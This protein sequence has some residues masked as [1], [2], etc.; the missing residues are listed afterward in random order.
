MFPIEVLNDLLAG[1]VQMY[2]QAGVA[3]MK[4]VATIEQGGFA[5]DKPHPVTG[6]AY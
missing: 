2:F 4:E 5:H 1:Q 6:L 3:V